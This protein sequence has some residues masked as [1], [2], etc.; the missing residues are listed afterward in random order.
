MAATLGP[1]TAL[2]TTRSST[3]DEATADPC[4]LDNAVWHSL[5]TAHRG[6][7]QARGDALRY[8]PDVSVF[9]A[10]PDDAQADAA[11]W[12][13]LADLVG[14]RSRAV[15]FRAAI[16]PP[17]GWAVA[18]DIPGVQLVADGPLG[19]ADPDAVSI[20][21]D[22]VAEATDLVLRT[23]PGPWRPRTH[24]LGRYVGL[25]RDGRLV[26]LAGQRLQPR[27]W[28]EISA[29]CTDPEARGQGLATRLVR[30][31]AHLVEA[32]GRT[33]FIQTAADNAPAIRLYE[34]LGFVTRSTVVAQVLVPPARS[35]R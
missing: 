11:S 19:V 12:R 13:D 22:L 31:V 25:E 29:V 30:H 21:P 5:E 20:G 33:P 2:P 18:H 16:T 35:E 17:R 6:V 8:D 34:A 23:R 10:L 26:A 14:P 4:L 15:L 27:G 32:G 24:E 28:C 7:A 1:M 9:S 3:R